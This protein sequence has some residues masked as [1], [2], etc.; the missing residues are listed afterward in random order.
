[1]EEVLLAAGEGDLTPLYALVTAL[2]EPYRE[3]SVGDRY[4]LPAPPGSGRYQT[5]CGT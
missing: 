5:F 3:R 1:M 4:R 2:K